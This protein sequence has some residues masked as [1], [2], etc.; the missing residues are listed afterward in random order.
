MQVAFVVG[1]DGVPREARVASSTDAA[2]DSVTLASVTGLRFTP[3]TVAGRAVPVRIELPVQWVPA[4]E[5]PASPGAPAVAVSGRALGKQR[6]GVGG[7]ELSDVDVVPRPRNIAVLQQALAEYYPRELR[8]AGV[9]GT[10]Q[11]RFRVDTQGMPRD[12][13]VTTTTEP[14]FNAATLRAASQLRFTPGQ[15]D[16]RPVD[17]WVELPIAW[18]MVR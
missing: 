11:V 9:E 15:K 4:P 3:A 18:S 17:V 16:G 1:D 5:Q 8:D 13:I 10:V 14:G 7:W 6:D 2:F 12:F